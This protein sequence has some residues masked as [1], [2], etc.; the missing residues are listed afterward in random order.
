VVVPPAWPG[1]AEA[2][3]AAKRTWSGPKPISLIGSTGSIGTQTLDIV[4][5][6]P[7]QYKV[8]ALSAGGNIGLLA[9][10]ARDAACRA[11]GC[12]RG[13]GRMQKAQKALFGVLCGA[14][15]GGCHAPPS[16]PH[17]AHLL[18]G[19]LSPPTVRGSAAAP[20]Q[21][22]RRASKPYRVAAARRSLTQHHLSGAPQVRK[23]KPSL[24]SI[25][26]ASK[27]AEF[28]A[29]ISDVQPQPESAPAHA[30]AHAHTRADLSRCHVTVPQS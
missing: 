7:E 11:C 26:D 30:L 22:T 29:L 13:S 19:R 21:H 3:A 8:V 20:Q 14:V 23:F 17:A 10:Q 18:L 6:F 1:R 2:P 24:V 4:G 27:V 5:E 28:K 9:E 16:R 12:E 25:A 15:G